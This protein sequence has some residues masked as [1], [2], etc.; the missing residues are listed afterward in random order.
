MNNNKKLSGTFVL[1]KKEAIHRWFAYM[2]GYSDVLVEKELELI[3]YDNIKTIYDPFGG[4]GTSL[5][6]ASKHNIDAYYSEVN[7]VMGFICDTKINDVL[8]AKNDPTIIDALKKHYNEIL[9]IQFKY[10]AINDYQGFEKYY[11]NDKLCELLQILEYIESISNIHA[12]NL[13]KVGIASIAIQI[14]KM[15]RRGDL[16]YAKGSEK[17][18]VNQNV[19]EVYL[20][21]LQ[22]IID[23]LEDEDVR[24]YKN[25]T[26][27]A[28]DSRKITVENMFD[29]VITSPPYLNGTNYIRNTKLEL[30]LLGFV[31]NESELP[32]LHSKGIIAGI[33]SVSRRS[34]VEILP[35]V[36]NYI[37]KLEPVAY[38]KRIPIMV[39]GY[40]Y[41]MDK[42]FKKLSKAIKPNGKFIMDI[43]DSMFAGV[44]I[45]THDVLVELAEMHGF[46]KYD[47]E[48]LRVRHSN[49]GTKLSQRVI[50][51]INE[52]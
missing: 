29:C 46:K 1:N 47:E 34:T 28:D 7:P 27:L 33:N 8:K 5:L 10:Y 41:D 30:K 49:N 39:A 24:L 31:E 52:K 19:K 35:C 17:E 25:V 15:I 21:K 3:G 37:D 40:F 38:D 18:K 22:I 9:N 23:D 4:S 51:F 26:R 16:R 36:K 32:A 43:G 48:I 44:H 50:R 45:P 11:E 20:N 2:E 13:A 12:Q 6:T 14:S 42:V